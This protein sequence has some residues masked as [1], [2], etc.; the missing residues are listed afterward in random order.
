[1]RCGF[2]HL[3]EKLGA[4]LL[5]TPLLLTLISFAAVAI[6]EG[7]GDIFRRKGEEKS[8]AKATISLSSSTMDL[9]IQRYIEE[10]RKEK[11]E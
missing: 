3:S 6:I 9:E 11:R 10:L 2:I 7:V 1:M 4:L 5:L 8:E